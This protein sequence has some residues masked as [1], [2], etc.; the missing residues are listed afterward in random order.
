[1]AELY[2][3]TS[4]NIK[5]TRNKI[6]TLCKGI[7]A[8]PDSTPIQCSRCNGIGV[9]VFT[10]NR[11]GFIMEQRTVCPAC[12][13]QG[14]ILNPKDQCS[15]CNGNKVTPDSITLEVKIQRG[16]HFGDRIVFEGQSDEF[17]GVVPGDVWVVISPID[18]DSSPFVRNGDDL[19][20]KKKISL[21]DALSGVN[22]KLKHLDQRE[23]T[24]KHQQI[25]S[26]GETITIKGNGMPKANS[27][28]FGDLKI[29]FEIIFPK[30]LSSQQINT[31]KKVLP[32]KANL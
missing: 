32:D 4:K 17:P 2:K 8:K 22:F 11:G 21:L 1:M 9:Q 25:I 13:G 12:H 18:N 30:K 7:G 6:C 5:L 31:L 24:V 3:G 26:P 27:S 19:L 20:F 28:E 23:V 16:S 15:K 29:T 14:K 10:T